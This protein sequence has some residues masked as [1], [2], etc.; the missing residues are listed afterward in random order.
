MRRAPAEGGG[1]SGS[2][3]GFV[4]AGISAIAFPPCR[5]ANVLPNR[6]YQDLADVGIALNDRARRMGDWPRSCRVFH[7]P[8]KKRRC[9]LLHR[10]MTNRQKLPK[11]L[12]IR[13]NRP[14]L[15]VEN[16]SPS[17][18]V[19]IDPRPPPQI[20]LSHRQTRLFLVNLV[21]RRH[22]HPSPP[23]TSAPHQ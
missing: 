14:P 16:S 9:R 10:R 20:F 17:R 18:A 1:F 3:V 12:P 11:H 21:H 2:T 8:N 6:K 7:Q 5:R 23:A 22:P 15:L 4:V 19:A 13:R